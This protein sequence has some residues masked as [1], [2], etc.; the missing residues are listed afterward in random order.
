MK[1]LVILITVCLVLLGA[2]SLSL[3][4]ELLDLEQALEKE[5]ACK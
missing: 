4:E 3:S 5:R 1:S 2:Q